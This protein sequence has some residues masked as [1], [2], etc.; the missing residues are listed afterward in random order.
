MFLYAKFL[1][2]GMSGLAAVALVQNSILASRNSTIE[3]VQAE[4]ALIIQANNNLNRTINKMIELRAIDEKVAANLNAQLVQI[5]ANIINQTKTLDEMEAQN[6]QLAA[7]LNA[8][9]PDDVKRVLD[10]EASER[11]SR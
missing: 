3:A 2:V 9:L 10:G 5:N 7:Y 11:R 1:L 4:I 6:A 8:N